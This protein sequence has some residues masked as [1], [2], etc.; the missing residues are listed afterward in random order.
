MHAPI[1]HFLAYFATVINYE[2]KNVYEID[3]WL[4]TIFEN[5]RR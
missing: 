2:R 5:T 1:Q 4:N 3:T